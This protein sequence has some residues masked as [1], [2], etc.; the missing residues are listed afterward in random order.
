MKEYSI[1]KELL[2]SKKTEEEYF[3]IYLG[4]NPSTKK[5]FKSPL[6]SDKNPTCAFYRSKSGLRFKDFALNKSYSFVDIV[7]EKYNLSYYKALKFIAKDVGIIDDI[8]HVPTRPVV[9]YDNT[10]IK[11]TSRCNIQV[12]V[13]DFTEK[14]LEWWAQY[15]I[16]L[17]MLKMFN[18]Y[19]LKAVFLNGR[20]NATSSDYSP[21]YGYYFGKKDG[22]ELWK[23]YFPKRAIYRFLLNNSAT[24][25]LSQIEGIKSDYIV[26]T[27]SYKDV[28]SLRSFGVYAIAPQSESVIMDEKIIEYLKRNFKTIIFNADWD[29]AGKL[30]MINNRRKYGGICITFSER[31]TWEKDFSDNVAKFGPNKMENLIKNLKQRLKL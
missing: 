26:I 4:I 18:V 23:I 20:L 17:D 28:I 9:K 8:I 25:G 14:E 15:N 19:S 3:S 21:I 1:S 10:L 12:Q 7:M 5:L 16:N 24:Q 30:F 29:R 22:I 6:R 13:K 2:L 27:K 11:E 31:K